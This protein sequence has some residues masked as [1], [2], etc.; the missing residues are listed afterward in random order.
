MLKFHSLLKPKLSKIITKLVMNFVLLPI[1]LVY[2]TSLSKKLVFFIQ[3][4][5]LKIC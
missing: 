4:G 5:I 2:N 1:T 3:K